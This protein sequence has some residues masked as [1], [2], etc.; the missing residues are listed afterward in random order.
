M[1]E[2]IIKRMLL[3]LKAMLA[4]RRGFVFGNNNVP[5]DEETTQA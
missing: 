3:M 2:I 5:A 1:F 4:I